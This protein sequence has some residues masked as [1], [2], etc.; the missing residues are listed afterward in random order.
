MAVQKQPSVDR[1]AMIMQ[2]T[3]QKVFLTA[4]LFAAFT[5]SHAQS[6]RKSPASAKHSVV[7]YD[8]EA[9]KTEVEVLPKSY[10][11]HDVYALASALSKRPEKNQYETSAKYQ[12]KL[13]AWVSYPLVGNVGVS[14][15]LAIRD[16][17]LSLES[18]YNADTETMTYSFD[19]DRQVS[20]EDMSSLY[21]TVDI[22][23]RVLAPAIGQTAMGIK[24]KYERKSFLEFGVKLVNISHGKPAYTFKVPA[25]AAKNNIGWSVLYI[26]KITEP[27]LFSEE[28]YH[29]PSLSEKY[30]QLVKSSGIIIKVSE[31]FI[32]DR[33]TGS[34]LAKQAIK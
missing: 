1:F 17:F 25:A 18:Q 29:T 15:K 10:K 11:G 6:A 8:S 19:A 33:Q 26:G 16:D 28:R 31:I 20:A 23:K 34:I 21:I 24:F 12:E 5:C 4:L 14:E 27:F 30:E 9:F 13:D 2:K 7:L 22:N 32:Y 3:K